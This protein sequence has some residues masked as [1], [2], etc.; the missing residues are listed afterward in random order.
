MTVSDYT[1][2][3]TSRDQGNQS[4]ENI[5]AAVDVSDAI[6]DNQSVENQRAIVIVLILPRQ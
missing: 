2:T 4:V 5:Q 6:I 3:V 1:S